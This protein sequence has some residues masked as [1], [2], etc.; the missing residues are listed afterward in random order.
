MRLTECSV[1]S[2]T[3]GISR[4]VHTV[5]PHVMTPS[6]LEGWV[7]RVA[8]QVARGDHAEDSRVELKR[9]WPK[10][11]AAARLIAGHANAARGATIL[12][13]IGLDE[14]TGVH[15]APAEELAD[16]YSSVKQSFEGVAP[17]LYDLNVVV[18]DKTLVAL[19]FDT[20]RAPY[21]VKNPAYGSP[22]G[23]SVEREVPWREGRSTLSAR[24]EHLL[25]MLVPTAE[26]PEIEV[27]SCKLSA[28]SEQRPGAPD[29]EKWYVHG[30]LYLSPR[31][32]EVV[33]PFHRARL[34]VAQ[35][36][37]RRIE[38][39]ASFRMFPPGRFALSGTK[40]SSHTDSATVSATSSEVIIA[41]PG[42]VIF[43]AQALSP[44]SQIS[45]G[46]SLEVRLALNIVGAEAPLSLSVL[47]APTLADRHISMEWATVNAAYP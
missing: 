34:T 26:L 21:V 33:I 37:D 18:G 38:P 1:N 36:V 43:E 41:G 42:K 24:R 15:G 35:G 27:L 3:L 9:E 22:G 2:G 13:I 30:T 29:V 40:I 17:T 44:F 7:L 23:G 47:L 32:S 19:L 11:K 10:P 46:T 12:W 4:S 5:W 6:A 25:R 45:A 28:R 39:W 16:W 31:G 8:D 20:D 14:I